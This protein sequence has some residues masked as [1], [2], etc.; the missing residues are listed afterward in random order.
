MSLRDQLTEDLKDAMR[1][2]DDVRKTT[3]RAVIAEIKKAE[4]PQVIEHRIAAG[5]SW[6]SV[7]AKHGADPAQLAASY[8]VS[9]EDPVP[10]ED[11]DTH[12]LSKLVVPL[13]VPAVT[14]DVVQALLAKQVKQR[15]DS[16][17]AFTKAGRQDLI[18]REAAELR[19]LETYL[20]AQLS[21]D[22]IAAEARA[23][24]GEVG[25]D[26]PGDKGKVMSALVPRLAGRAEGRT[27]NEVV[28]ELLSSMVTDS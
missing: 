14:D 6:R 27:I 17:E 26:G 25:A 16:I 20:P 3:L 9:V 18:D 5:D 1:A 13:P 22:D 2:G 10:P 24:I 4:V 19:I 21:R 15:R 23:V 28:T 12:P 7:A 8:G 11:E